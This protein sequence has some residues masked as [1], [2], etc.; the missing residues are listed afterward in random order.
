MRIGIASAWLSQ[1]HIRRIER[2]YPELAGMIERDSLGGDRRA[3]G[4]Y[5]SNAVSK[6]RA[7]GEYALADLLFRAA[8]DVNPGK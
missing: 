2:A 4:C 3:A 6:L 8:T 7:A 5:V 1:S